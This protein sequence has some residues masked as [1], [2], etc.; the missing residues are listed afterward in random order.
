MP[1][2]DLLK[3]GGRYAVQDMMLHVLDRACLLILF[4]AMGMVLYTL[5]YGNAALLVMEIAA[6]AA[7][8][9]VPSRFL[10]QAGI[11]R[12]RYPLILYLR[13]ETGR[14]TADIEDVLDREAFMAETA[15]TAAASLLF[16][17]PAA[18]CAFPVLM[19][20]V[21]SRRKEEKAEHL[22]V[23]AAL[24]DCLPVLAVCAAVF[25]TMMD[26]GTGTDQA[27]AILMC[28]GSIACGGK[29][30]MMAGIMAEAA[31]FAGAAGLA[32]SEG[33]VSVPEYV[34]PAVLVTAV[35][36]SGAAGAASQLVPHRE[37]RFLAAVCTFLPSCAVSLAGGVPALCIIFSASVI[38]LLLLPVMAA[39][40]SGRETEWD[41]D[42]SPLLH[43]A[44]NI[45]HCPAAAMGAAMSMILVQAG[46]VLLY[47]RGMIAWRFVLPSVMLYA[48]W[49]SS[50]F[51]ASAAS[52]VREKAAMRLH[53]KENAD[54]IQSDGSRRQ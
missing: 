24:R 30:G 33:L 37:H 11:I 21:L 5:M 39:A 8:G 3:K 18:V 42:D 43:E 40:L 10:L 9:T 22:A 2:F 47:L 27:A 51:S 6:L 1:E 38:R 52:E 46:F 26:Q 54:G 49:A 48:V 15:L 19:A 31:V 29:S 50:S 17:L 44:L 14:D 45:R 53:G 32:L 12:V 7:A 13:K 25:F 41:E 4:Y 36:C 35:L 20:A 16:S 23:R 34:L 28:T